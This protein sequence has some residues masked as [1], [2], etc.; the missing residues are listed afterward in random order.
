MRPSVV[1]YAIC[2]GLIIGSFLNVVAYRLPRGDSVVFP[3]SRCPRCGARIRP[4]DLIPVVSWVWLRGRCRDCGGTI[5]W[6]YPA[7]EGLTAL[8]W[9]L[10]AWW[11][12]WSWETAL[13][14]VV[15]SFLIALSTIDLEWK[16]LPD[17]LTYPL[18]IVVVGARLWMGPEPWWWYLGGAALGAGMLLTLYWLSPL[19]FGKEGMGLGDVKLMV[20][21][22]AFT[23]LTGTV[24]TLFAASLAGLVVGLVLQRM[25]RLGEQRRIPFGPFL[26]GGALLSWLYG[27]A[28][29]KAYFGLFL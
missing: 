8:L 17:E 27:D 25:D 29:M 19:L 23:G 14:L 15:I 11:Y 13:G 24:I 22:G 20:G 18:A 28:L 26:A 12:G 2:M 7:V 9:G 3:P 10:A 16:I 4:R 21:L 1:I 6:R 5:S